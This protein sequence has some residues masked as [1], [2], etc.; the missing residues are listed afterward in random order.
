MDKKQVLFI[1]SHLYLFWTLGCYY[2]FELLE[3]YELILIVNNEYRCDPFF[4]KIITFPQIIEV[5]YL[6]KSSNIISK[7]INYIATI[8]YTFKKYQ[9]K[10]IF[11]YNHTYVFNKYVFVKASELS[12]ESKVI[13][14]QNGQILVGDEKFAYEKSINQKLVD[15][16]GR[17]Q[18][19]FSVSSLKFIY[20][21]LRFSF[22]IMD[23]LILPSFFLKNINHSFYCKKRAKRNFF[24]QY[25]VFDRIIQQKLFKELKTKNIIQI[26]CPISTV[27]D[28][29]NK[30][31]YN[32]SERKQIV[33][34]PSFGFFSLK[35]DQKVIN[36]WILV[37]SILQ[38]KFPDYNICMKLH[39]RTKNSFIV[40]EILNYLRNK[41]P[42]IELL[43]PALNA[44]ELVLSSKIIVGDVS[45]IIWWASLLRNKVVISIRMN[46]KYGGD[47]M[48]Y[49]EDILYF[50]S[51][52]E[53][54]NYNFANRPITKRKKNL[55]DENLIPDLRAAL[56]SLYYA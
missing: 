28:K 19:P 46:Q 43:D 12:P 31:L 6:P 25:F 2:V 55:D 8:N 20:R 24:H 44:Q 53:F 47:E 36:N 26:K 56:D 17:F 11:Q 4:Q 9:P 42:K 21:L 10:F 54:K 35:Q 38:K 5:I 29:Y 23:D 30:F 7:H 40:E 27:S 32:Y 13:H 3:E 14:Y 18:I 48:K 50:K 41:C 52:K 15:I 16:K 37:I 33:I 1:S 45:T 49:Y 39:P 51:V 22:H 34:F